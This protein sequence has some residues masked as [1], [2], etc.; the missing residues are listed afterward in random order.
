VLARDRQTVW[1][2]IRSMH[3]VADKQFLA[4]YR[5]GRLP[6]EAGL[7]LLGAIIADAP[8]IPS[9]LRPPKCA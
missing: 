5:R 3:T 8:G 1:T 6:E 9:Q 4:A 2:P 7:R